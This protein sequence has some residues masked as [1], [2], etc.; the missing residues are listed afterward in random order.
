MSTNTSLKKNIGFFASL[1]LVM[2][3]VIGAG[4]FFKASSVTEVTGST[5]MALFVWLLGGIMTIC[6]GLTGAELAAAIPETGG[7]TKY[8]EY[9]Y[10]D[11]WGFLSGWAQAFIY[12]PANIA[13]LAIIFGTQI[14]NL[15]HLSTTLLL[16]IAILSAVSI[17]LINFL[18]SKA[19]GTLQSITLGIGLVMVVYL[20]INATFLMTLPIHQIEGNLNAASEASSILFGAGGGKLVTIGILI[21]VYGTMNGYTMTGMRIPYAMAERNQLPLKRLFLDL[22][23]SRT[24]WLGG[25]IQ[26]VIAVIMMLLGAFDTITNMLIF[27]IW[28]FYCM[29]FLAVFLLRKREPELHRPYKVPLYPVI[30]MIALLAGTFVL[31]NTLLTQPLLAITGIGVTMLGIPI[32]YYQKKTLKI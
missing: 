3:S 1:S 28:T 11:F 2:G 7:L 21:S 30:P 16:P 29:A 20:L 26:I 9:T 10:G 6:A 4:V 22:L 8:I 25:M 5:S 13:A 17:L 23:P 19:G 18:G 12:F 32:Y 15:F 14:I 31:L 27:V 24:P